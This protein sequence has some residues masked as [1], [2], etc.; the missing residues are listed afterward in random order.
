MTKRILISSGSELEKKY[1][2]SR[3]VVQEPFCFVA[4]TTG[5][6]ADGSGFADSV[7][8]QAENAFAIVEKA[9]GQEGFKLSDVVRATYYIT[10][11]DYWA[12]IQPVLAAKFGDIRPAATCVIAG[13]V[14]PAMKF[15]VELTAMR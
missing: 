15:E 10:S 2:Y 1:G 3:A 14:N 6:N 5:P 11:P 8:V 12:E 13:L 7:V 9:M 4:G